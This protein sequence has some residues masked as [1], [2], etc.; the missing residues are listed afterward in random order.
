VGWS[1]LA[2]DAPRHPEAVIGPGLGLV[3]TALLK[4]ANGSQNAG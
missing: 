2:R 3:L 1:S 4:V